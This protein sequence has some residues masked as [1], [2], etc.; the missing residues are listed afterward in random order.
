MRW[1]GLTQSVNANFTKL[2]GKH[3][4]HFG[5]EFRNARE[6]NDNYTSDVTPSL[7]F[8][9]TY[10]RGPNDTSAAPTIGGE[11][12]SFLLGVPAGSMTRSGSY[13][14]QENYLGLYVQD[15]IRLSP[16][17]TLNLGI[18]Y[19]I[20]SPVTERFNRSVAHFAYDQPSPIEAQ[21]R[22]NYVNPIPELPLSQFR[23]RGGLTFAGVDGNP[24]R[25]WSGEKNNFMPRIGLAYQLSPKTVLR[26]GY[27]LFFDTAGLA[28]NNSIQTGFSMSTP[29]QASMDS[30]LT[31]VATLSNPFPNGLLTPLG[32]KGGLSTNL[33]QSISF[34]PEK[35]LNPYSQRW[36][37]GFQR[38]LGAGFM[39]DA[40]YVGN[41]ATRISVARN[42][43]ALPAQYLSKS[44]VRD[45]TTIKYLAQSFPNPLYGT[46]SI[47]GT[48]IS[49]QGLLVPYPQFGSVSVNEPTGYSWYHSM[50]IRAEKRFSKG[51]TLNLAYTWAKTMEAIAFLNPSD[52]MPY[53][54]IS[55]QDRLHR[56]SISGIWDL[57]FGRGK[58]F[59]SQM[60]AVL[61]F[62]A[63]GWQLNGVMQRQSGPPLV[64]GDVWT[65][66]TG[67]T[68]KVR[69]SKNER[70]VDRWFNVDAGF[71][72]ISSQQLGSNIRVSPVRFSNLRADGQA[73]WDFS[74][75]KNFKM[76]EKWTTQFR[77]ECINAWNHPN[78][79]AP[80]MSPTS[81]TFGQITDQD[82][83]RSWVLSL[84][85]SF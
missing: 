27:G 12:A 29:I 23:L 35:M 84:K 55:A 85:V 14:Q 68:N 7:I 70:S 4:F 67:D 2:R 37:F 75:F 76:T 66:F 30:G 62:I 60:P 10:T 15:D 50:Q 79:I 83:T 28:V 18:R 20:E 41:R 52:P 22:A 64:W 3:S 9:S 34:F 17:L 39:V 1:S 57:P 54:Q 74:L 81:S 53:E 5:A 77:A 48:N 46:N 13:A 80:N 21:A 24:R 44:G 72:R 19:E 49:R 69:L 51:Y 40:S 45:E 59:G 78:L 63:G 33:G 8:N 36:S 82:A 6:F 56:L 42:L 16:K 31:Y 58:R 38:L 65:L 32:A 43:N 47:Y 25:L 26:T 71:N 11:I 73:R 61:N